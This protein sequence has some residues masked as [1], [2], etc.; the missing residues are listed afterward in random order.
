MEILNKQKLKYIALALFFILGGGCFYVYKNYSDMNKNKSYFDLYLA[1]IYNELDETTIT[2]NT[3]FLSNIKNTNV[4]F[5]ANLKLASLSQIKNYD[6]FE[7]DL[8]ILKNSIL[9]NDLMMLNEIKDGVFFN[10][11]ASIYYLNSNLNN[12]SKEE[13]DNN[14]N[15]F[16]TKAVSFYLNDN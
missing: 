10:E 13:L 1:N 12:I 6:N 5:F 3:S 2:S 8:I 11:T 14:A 16:F 4:S 7:K 15:N 9:N